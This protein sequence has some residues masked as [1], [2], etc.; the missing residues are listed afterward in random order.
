MKVLILRSKRLAETST[1]D[2]FS[3][4]FDTIYSERVIGNIVGE[5][6]FCSACGPDCVNCR[7]DLERK[8]AGDIAAV[9]DLPAVLPHLLETPGDY[10]PSDIPPHDILMAIGVHEQILLAMLERLAGGPTRGVVVPLEAPDWISQSAISRAEE[11]C[12]H[13]GIE[14][15][16]P[17]PFCDFDP[18][19][20]SV[21]DEFRRTFCI[22]KPE[23]ELS[24][25]DGR[26]EKAHV[27]VSAACG[28]TY[29]IARW[30]TGKRV[31]DDLKYD[32]IARR[33][34]SY[35]CTASMKWDNELGDT[36]MHVAGK[37]HY[38]ILRQLGQES[39][40][41]PEMIASPIGVMVHK[42]LSARENIQ[43][44]E[45]ATEAILKQL[46][47]D[48]SVSLESLRTQRRITPAAAYTAVLILTQQG[49]IRTEGDL[50]L[51]V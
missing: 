17:K 46:A 8:F 47:T 48:G 37:A 14:L 34:H 15:S 28:A 45:Q 22:G 32:V 5:K 19:P 23:V 39:E 51:P 18:P 43:N 50:I 29:Y 2:A 31:D 27:N 12:R 30:L 16:L 44:I 1:R 3:Q 10:V 11:I 9:I 25:R 33:L 6:D 21:L 49:K 7:Q 40:D 35:P 13:S 24:V 20:G 4:E 41:D 26:I 36:V 38:E 42:P